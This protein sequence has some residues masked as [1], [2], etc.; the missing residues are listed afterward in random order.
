[1]KQAEVLA[2]PELRKACSRPTSADTT[3]M[4]HLDNP[5]QTLSLRMRFSL[6]NL[7]IS[8]GVRRGLLTGPSI[9]IDVGSVDVGSHVL[10]SSTAAAW[11]RTR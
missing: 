10:T 8:L 7:A 1:M 9:T 2:I 4:T 6:L 11:T 3:T 5:I